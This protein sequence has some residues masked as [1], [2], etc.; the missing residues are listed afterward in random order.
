MSTSFSAFPSPSSFA[1]L[2]QKSLGH[3]AMNLLV[4]QGGVTVTV[5]SPS[6]TLASIFYLRQN[7]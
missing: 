3:A 7:E 2:H 1:G 6:E 5:S 4:L